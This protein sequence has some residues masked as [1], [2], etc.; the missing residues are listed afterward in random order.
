MADGTDNL[1]RYLRALTWFQSGTTRQNKQLAQKAVTP[2]IPERVGASARVSVG[3]GSGVS[4]F[5]LKGAVVVTSSDG[6]LTFSYPQS[7]E[8]VVDS[9]TITIGAI[10]KSP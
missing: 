2:A 9:V 10:A 3:V 8:T 6:L 7:V 4:G 5:A 1:S